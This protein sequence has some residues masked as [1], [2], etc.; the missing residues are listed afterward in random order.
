MYSSLGN[1]FYLLHEQKD[2]KFL[3]WAESGIAFKDVSG[4][5]INMLKN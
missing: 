2:T 5:I 1:Q 4:I 3:S